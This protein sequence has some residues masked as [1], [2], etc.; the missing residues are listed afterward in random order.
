ME[1]REIPLQLSIN[2]EN[3]VGE[4]MI[5]ADTVRKDREIALLRKENICLIEERRK[6]FFPS[7]D[8]VMKDRKIA[9]LIKENRCLVDERDRLFLASDD[10]VMKERKIAL[11]IKENESLIAERDSSWMDNRTLLLDKAELVARQESLLQEN[12]ELKERLQL[13]IDARNEVGDMMIAV[14]TECRR[15]THLLIEE[16]NV[17]LHERDEVHNNNNR[18][19][20]ATEPLG[21]SSECVP[22]SNC[23]CRV[24]GVNIELSGAFCVGGNVYYCS[25]CYTNRNSE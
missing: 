20:V 4:M 10:D 1:D 15:V 25:H 13:T 18:C 9:L 12:A 11:L 22:S 3:E 7:D 5:G 19:N 6:F 24:C 17:A 14:A 16:R 21:Q 8:D 23:L 2:E